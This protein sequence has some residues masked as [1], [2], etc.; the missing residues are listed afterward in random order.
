MLIFCYLHIFKLEL[1]KDFFSFRSEEG[2]FEE[3]AFLDEAYGPDPESFGKIKDLGIC[4][5]LESLEA[6]TDDL[7]K[8]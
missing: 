5:V 6:V 2:N 1:V 4:Q 7:I 8:R 3:R